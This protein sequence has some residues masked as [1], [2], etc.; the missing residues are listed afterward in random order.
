MLVVYLKIICSLRNKGYLRTFGKGRPPTVV[1]YGMSLFFRNELRSQK[2]RIER[3]CG[4]GPK[5]TFLKLV[6]EKIDRFNKNN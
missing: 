5:N 6:M 1:P 3:S 2:N 4:E